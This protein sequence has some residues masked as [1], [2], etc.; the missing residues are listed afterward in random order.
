MARRLLLILLAGLIVFDAHKIDDRAY[1]LLLDSLVLAGAT[2]DLVRVLKTGRAGTW[3][4]GTATREHQ[5]RKY[6]RYVYEGYAAIAL[7]TAALVWGI[8]RQS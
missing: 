2:Y 7:F 6:W 1:F 3:T 4:D 8:F 5:P